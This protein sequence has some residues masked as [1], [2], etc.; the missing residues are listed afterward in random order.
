MQSLFAY[1]LAFASADDHASIGNSNANNS[2]N[3]GKDFVINTIVKDAGIN[4]I[5]SLD[6]GDADGVGTNP[7]H[8]FQMLR[9]HQ[10]AGQL[11]FIT[12]QAKKYAQAHVI[13]TTLHGSIHGLGVISIIM[14]GSFGMQLL[15]AFLVI[16]L[17][18]EDVSTNA[19]FLK[20]A[21]IFHCGSCNIYIHPA[22]GTIFML[23]TVNC[24][25]AIQNI[26][27]GI[28]DGVLAG[29][30]C[31]ALVPHVLQ[32]NNLLANLLLGQLFATNMLVG[33]MV[34]A[35][36]TMVDAIIGQI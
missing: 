4:I 11:I 2:N 26:L 35:V 27:N 28:I 34:G 8:C 19:C 30:Q 10:K 9:M 13:N 36:N 21:I 5:S 24:F 18:E 29:L 23:N 1:L 6:A 31:Q 3:L 25:D 32:G 14:L 17:L 33:S 16:G 7:M 15:I 22:N 20:L 12:L